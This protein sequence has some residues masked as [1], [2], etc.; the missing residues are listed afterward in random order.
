MNK[1][2]FLVVMAGL[3][4][5]K[6]VLAEEQPKSF[7]GEE[8]VVTATKTENKRKDISNAVIIIDDSAIKNSSAQTLGE[9]LANQSGLDTRTYGNYGGASQE[10]QIRGMSADGTQVFV[11]GVNVNSLSLGTADV[12]KIPLANIERI[13]IVK[14]AGSLL[15]G[16]GAGGGTINIFTRQ[17]VHDKMSINVAGSYGTQNT[18]EVSVAQGMPITDALG[19]CLTLGQHKTDGFRDNSDLDHKNASLNLVY[20]KG[21]KLTVTLYG[22]YSNRQYGMPGVKPPD[23]TADYYI[24]GQKYYNSQSST[25]LNRHED[26]DANIVLKVN[27]KARENIGFSLKTDYRYTKSYNYDR[28]VWFGSSYKTWVTND[29]AGFEGNMNIE[30]FKGSEL[31]LGA[32]YKD[33]SNQHEQISLDDFGKDIAGTRSDM[34]HGLNSKAAFAEVQYRPSNYVKVQFGTRE[35]DNS[36]FGLANI[37]RYALVLNPTEKTSLK[38]N[39]GSHFKAPTMNDLFWPDDGYT[40]GNTFL[41]PETGWHTDITCEHRASEKVFLTAS[42][43]NWDVKNKITWAED[44]AQPTASVGYYYWVPTNLDSYHAQGVELGAVIG[45]FQNSVLSLHYTRLDAV[46]EKTGSAARQSTYTPAWQFK[47]E[48]AYTDKRSG[49]TIAPSVSY[50]DKRPYYAASN[51]TAEPTLFISSCWIVD[52]KVAKRMNEHWLVSLAGNN[53]LDER[54]QTRLQGFTNR[55]TYGTTLSGYPGAERSVLFSLAYEY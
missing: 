40:K 2:V 55:T 12:S 46:E 1:K 42:Y 51:K 11:N 43:F 4:C 34:L 50:M 54:Y 3:L 8:T 9:L 35:E 22:D 53:L 48:L 19:Y 5:S 33:Y 28:S 39:R 36:M 31:L 32:E 6:G 23:G 20:D 7:V 10:I 29:V 26:D 47:G 16:S 52:L 45:P 44:P 15:Y 21:E 25:L 38:L 14:G 18:C 13:E 27:G 30:P 37:F 49:L 24:N 41:K 17:P